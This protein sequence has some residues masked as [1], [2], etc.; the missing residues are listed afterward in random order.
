MDPLIDFALRASIF[1]AFFL[2]ISYCLFRHIQN[3]QQ[4]HGE[5]HGQNNLL[6]VLKHY[7]FRNYQNK[8]TK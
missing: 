2:T 5:P 8:K 6:K 7:F 1:M 4:R 3:I